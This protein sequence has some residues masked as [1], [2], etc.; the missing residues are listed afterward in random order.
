MTSVDNRKKLE[1]GKKFVLESSFKPSG[2]QPRAI[3]ELLTGLN[4]SDRSQVLLGATGTGKTFTMAKI[5]EQTQRP[6]IILAPNKTLAA[7]LYGEFKTFFLQ[8]Q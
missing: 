5:I 8:M 6:A 1:G 2:D 3:K 7:Q 4:S